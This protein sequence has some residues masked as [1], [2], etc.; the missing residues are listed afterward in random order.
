MRSTADGAGGTMITRFP[1]SLDEISSG[2]LTEILRNARLLS[3]GQTVDAFETKP[4]GLGFGQTGESAR[5]TLRYARSETSQTAPASV[6][7]KFATSDS[8][9]RKASTAMGLYQREINFYKVLAKGTNVRAP[10]CYF[11][12]ATEDGEFFALLLE[13]F[14]RH[15]PGDETLGLKVEEARLAVDLMTQ[16]HGPYWGKMS[17][18][19]LAPLRMPARDRYVGAWNEMEARFGDQVPDRLRK[20]RESYLDAIDPLQEWL[21]SQPATLGHGDLKLDNMLFSDDGKDPVVAVDWQAVRPL[22]GVRDF[23]YTISHSMN[24]EDRRANEIEL[25][26]RYVERIGAFGIDYSFEEAREDYRKAMLFD[27]CTV[28]YIVGININTHERALRRKHALMQ[29]SVTAMLDWDVLDLL[30]E[31]A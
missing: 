27:F 26:R 21:V 24:V 31:F 30:P 8:V 23:A 10:A 18:V 9:R 17:D 6:F 1:V 11:A 7:V 22:K 16:L 20:A 29:R 19:D 5:V 13:D 3:G 2:W 15:R 12:E 4:I 25:L 28:L 14:P